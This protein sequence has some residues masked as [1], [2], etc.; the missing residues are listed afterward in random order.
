MLHR[1]PDQVIELPVLGQRGQLL[2]AAVGFA[3]LAALPAHWG[4]S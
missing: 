4:L 1:G 3:A 2:G